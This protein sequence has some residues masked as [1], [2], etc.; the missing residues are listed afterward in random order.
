MR[1]VIGACMSSHSTYDRGRL[2]GFDGE[3]VGF[4]WGAGS[5]FFGLFVLALDLG[6]SFRLVGTRAGD[7]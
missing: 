4:D 5:F 7:M 3:T 2:G 1:R 6:K